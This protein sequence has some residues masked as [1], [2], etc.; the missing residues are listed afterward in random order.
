[1]RKYSRPT[2]SRQEEVHREKLQQLGGKAVCRPDKLASVIVNSKCFFR[3][4]GISQE[5][6]STNH[7]APLLI[8]QQLKLSSPCI[9]KLFF[10]Q[11]LHRVVNGLKVHRITCHKARGTRE[12]FTAARP[13]GVWEIGGQNQISIRFK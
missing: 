2:V 9:A 12:D 11:N 8:V 3:E 4:Y 6:I 13:V 7:A 10:R 5:S 1:L